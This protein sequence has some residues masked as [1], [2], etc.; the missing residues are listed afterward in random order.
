[1]DSVKGEAGTRTVGK[2]VLKPLGIMYPPE[3]PWHIDDERFKC[4]GFVLSYHGSQ[5]TP[6]ATLETRL[7]TMLLMWK[8]TAPS[9]TALLLLVG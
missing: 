1:M 2:M 5:L 4:S 8:D 9:E 7:R 3:A 6:Y